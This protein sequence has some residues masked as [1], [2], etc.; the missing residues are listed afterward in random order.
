[1]SELTKLGHTE[2]Q[3]C[4]CRAESWEMEGRVILNSTVRNDSGKYVIQII[5]ELGIYS[6][7][8]K[9]EFSFFKGSF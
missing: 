4:V 3:S 7:S 2:V 6:F 8:E 9:E 1:M 5:C